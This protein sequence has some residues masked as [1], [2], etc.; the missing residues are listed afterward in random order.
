MHSALQDGGTH[1]DM[2]KC[3]GDSGS[4]FCMGCFT[5]SPR[6]IA[7]WGHRDAALAAT[8]MREDQVTFCTDEQVLDTVARLERF[9]TTD[10]VGCFEARSQVLGFTWSPYSLLSDAR[11]TGIMKPCSQLMHDWMHGL[12][13]GACLIVCCN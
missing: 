13:S 12:F 11:L 4:R 7:E 8:P 3:K 1:K 5:L 6:A 10:P 2:W 9:K